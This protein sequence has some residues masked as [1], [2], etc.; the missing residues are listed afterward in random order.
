MPKPPVQVVRSQLPK[1]Q[2]PPPVEALQESE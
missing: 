2:Y 1:E